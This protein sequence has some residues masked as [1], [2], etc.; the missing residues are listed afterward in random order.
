[1]ST[2]PLIVAAQLENVLATLSAVLAAVTAVVS[3]VVAARRSRETQDAVRQVRE[4][5]A[6]DAISALDLASL[7]TYLYETLG[8]VPLASY[9][10]DTQTRR[11]VARALD[12]IENFVTED[13]PLAVDQRDE[14]AAMSSLDAARQ[15]LAQRDTWQAL[16][17]LRRSIE[18]DLRAFADR[19][20]V[21]VPPR[22]G[23]GRL[24][25]ELESSDL[26]PA[27]VTGPLRYAVDIANSAI[28]GEDVSP[29]VADEAIFTATRALSQI[30]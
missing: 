27:E 25:A 15:A 9:A 13:Q 21:V 24:L 12:D 7:G 18:I 29:H 4:T 30:R 16:A 10:S 17:Q 22:A 8:S 5:R 28:H 3:G 2:E 23:A 6:A 26:L 20:S 19:H 1:L 14:R 11:D